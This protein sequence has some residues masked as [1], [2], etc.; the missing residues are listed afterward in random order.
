MTC[1]LKKLSWASY[2]SRI[3][4]N[5]WQYS[6]TKLVQ[7]KLIRRY[8]IDDLKISYGKG[9][10]NL[11]IFPLSTTRNW[12]YHSVRIKWFKFCLHFE[13]FDLKDWITE[14]KSKYRNNLF[15]LNNYYYEYSIYFRMLYYLHSVHFQTFKSLISAEIS[16]I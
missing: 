13:R 16:G 4:W 11:T 10:T 14:M 1:H 15:W 2:D 8:F 9:Y 6:M 3:S 7:L 12:K 5:C